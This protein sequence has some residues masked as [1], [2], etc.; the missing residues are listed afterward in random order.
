ML[1]SPELEVRSFC[2]R[3]PH[4]FKNCIIHNSWKDELYKYITGIIQKNNHKL[5]A[6]QGISERI[7]N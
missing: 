4:F 5:L 7:W 1:I 3:L 2:F 6:I